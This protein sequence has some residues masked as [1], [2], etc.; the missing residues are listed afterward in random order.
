MGNR[1]VNCSQ[2][3]AAS[4]TVTSLNP[5]LVLRET[6]ALANSTDFCNRHLLPSTCLAPLRI[7]RDQLMPTGCILVA[8]DEFELMNLEQQSLAKRYRVCQH[9]IWANLNHMIMTLHC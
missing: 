8:R 6:L 4:G 5:T 9:P 2:L 1:G 3:E 7:T